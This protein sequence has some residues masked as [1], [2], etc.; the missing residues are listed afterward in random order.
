MPALKLLVPY[1]LLAALVGSFAPSVAAAQEAPAS[2]DLL[3]EA[4]QQL[5]LARFDDAGRALDTAARGELDRTRLLRWLVLHALLAYAAEQLGAT[6]EALAGLACL[7]DPSEPEPTSLPRVLRARLA[8]MRAEGMH[9]ELGAVVTAT[10]TDGGRDVGIVGE[11][12]ADAG[13]LVR[14]VR[15]VAEIDGATAVEGRPHVTSIVRGD[16]SREVLVHYR[17][18]AIGPGGAIVATHGTE[19][20]PLEEVV[21]G[22]PVDQTPVHVAVAITIGTLIAGAIGVAFAAV[23]TDGFR[24]GGDV[25]IHGPTVGALFSF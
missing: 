22:T 12:R 14:E 8:E 9:V 25:V 7:L 20:A 5:E 21:P 15:V 1:V 4:A 11:I 23:E 18:E 10:P 17:L 13:H 24:R 3:D 19:T 6:E 16:T 2:V